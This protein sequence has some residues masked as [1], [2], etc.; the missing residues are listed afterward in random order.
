MAI[1]PI[2]TVPSGI[3]SGLFNVSI[4]FYNTDTDTYLATSAISDFDPLTDP[5]DLVLVTGGNL[6]TIANAFGTGTTFTVTLEPATNAQGTIILEVP[7]NRISGGNRAG[8]SH[9]ILIDARD[10]EPRITDWGIPTTILTTTV[11]LG[12]T[13]NQNISGLSTT[14]FTVVGDSQVQITGLTGSNESYT[15]ALSIPTEVTGSFTLTLAEDSVQTHNR[16]DG[17][18]ADQSSPTITYDTRPIPKVTSWTV[19]SEIQL[20]TTAIATLTFDQTV[21]GLTSSDFS[22]NHIN[23]SISNISGSGTTYQITVTLPQNIYSR[24]VLTLAADSVTHS[25]FTGPPTANNS[26]SFVFDTTGSTSRGQLDGGEQEYQILASTQMTS[27]TFSNVTG[28]IQLTLTDHA[29]GTWVVQRQ[30]PNNESHWIDLDVSF[31]NEGSKVFYSSPFTSYRLHGGTVGATAWLS[32]V[33]L[34]GVVDAGY[35]KSQLR[36]VPLIH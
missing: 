1:Q 7:S 31:T 20:G 14:D 6:A 13:F 5:A 21:T 16:R 8:H 34:R 35:T 28:L 12:I 4:R 3:Q 17:P 26:P 11:N 2:L 30:S 9:P 27:T 22:F 25:S 19:P 15:L 24:M 23:T 29:G 18:E 36:V 33:H 10:P 32:P